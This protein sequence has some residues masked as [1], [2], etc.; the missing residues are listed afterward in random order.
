MV[1]NCLAGQDPS[2][3]YGTLRMRGANAML[4]ELLA[5]LVL[6]AMVTL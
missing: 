4:H 2:A 3:G 5:A 1:V 6:P